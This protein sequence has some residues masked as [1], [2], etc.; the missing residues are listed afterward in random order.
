MNI[1]TYD[2]QTSLDR[3]YKALSE[4]SKVYYSRYGD[5]ELN[6]M[7]GVRTKS[8]NHDGSLQLQKDL[9]DAFIIEDPNYIKA[10]MV[11]DQIFDGIRMKYPENSV[12][13]D[14]AVG[15]IEKF[16][17]DSRE[18]VFYDS[19]S[20]LTYL[21]IAAQDVMVN[22]LDT[23]IRPKKK[24]FIGSVDKSLIEKLIGNIDYYINVPDF[25]AYYSMD[26][27]WN[28]VLSIVDDVELVLPTAG[29]AGN[30]V[31]GRLWDL[32]KNVHCIE[33]GSVV[34]AAVGLTSRSTW[35]RA[36]GKVNNVL[37]K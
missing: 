19:H 27:W 1:Q 7:Y 30:V 8:L 33:L 20:L 26:V 28:D 31:C 15:F 4:N 13:N 16:Y 36:E 17:A 34:D 29:P 18:E 21:A 23:F 37:L 5:A 35:H 25:N 3:L 9:I 32:N 10:V 12:A 2:L 24:L 11:N 14:I 6:F 22:F